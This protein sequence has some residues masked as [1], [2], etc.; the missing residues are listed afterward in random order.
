MDALAFEQRREA[1]VYRVDLEEGAIEGL[2]VRYC[3]ALDA[4]H[5]VWVTVM[6]GADVCTVSLAYYA[7]KHGKR[8]LVN[9]QGFYADTLMHYPNA[10][11]ALRELL[12]HCQDFEGGFSRTCW[13]WA[14]PVDWV[15][16]DAGLNI[17][18]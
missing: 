7:C 3:A 11:H 10:A 8:K 5:E 2:G 9:A 13:P 16:P 4:M 17:T 15:F 6:E 14:G 18:A 12:R 1:R